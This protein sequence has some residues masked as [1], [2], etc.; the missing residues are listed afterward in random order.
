M[1]EESIQGLL[2]DYLYLFSGL[3]A[4]L[5]LRLPKQHGI[6]KVN[7]D[8]PVVGYGEEVMLDFRRY[9]THPFFIKK[10]P[11]LELCILWGNAL[12]TRA[13]VHVMGFVTSVPMVIY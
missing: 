5:T 10:R 13:P 6:I 3:V 8:N 1:T 9:I 12:E 2:K 4:R 11:F 7:S